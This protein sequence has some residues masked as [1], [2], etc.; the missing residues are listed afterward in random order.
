MRFSLKPDY[1]ETRKRCEAFWEGEL[2]DRAM[3]ALPVFK[4]ESQRIKIQKKSYK[5]LEDRWTDYDQRVKEDV[6]ML[7]NIEFLG[8]ALPIAWPNLGPEIFSAWYGCG[9]HFGETTTWSDPCIL[10]WACDNDKAVFDENHPLYIGMHEYTDR[11]LE[12]ANGK[13][14]VGLTDFHPGGD[15][16]AALRDPQNLAIDMLYDVDYV[17]E[18]VEKSYVDFFKVYDL[19][20]KKFRSHDMPITTWTPLINEGTYYVPSNDFSCMISTKM[21]E[22]VFL[23]GIIRECK[24]Y[25]RSVY[26]LDG[27]DALRHLDVLL[28]IRELDAVQWVPGAGNEQFDRWIDVYQKI[29]NRG[30]SIQIVSI[31]INELDSLFE[32]LSPEG[33]FISSVIGVDDK[34]TAQ[35]VLERI[36]NWK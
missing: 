20:Y 36:K 33:V 18:M 32:T 4:D 10:D 16:V 29:Q 35:Y 6:A 7:H 26:H 28:D 23:E 14:I 13:F 1:D 12:A 30:K 24:Y 22:D 8:D 34:Q 5:S 21:F 25:D 19:F 17:K 3:V 31:K 2:Y 27:P 9:Y 11:L 15:H